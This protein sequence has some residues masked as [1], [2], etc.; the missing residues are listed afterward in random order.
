MP[1]RAGDASA[2]GG[3]PPPNGLAATE[4]DLAEAR[5][6]RRMRDAVADRRAR[7]PC[8]L[9]RRRAA[10]ATNDNIDALGPVTTQVMR[11]LH[12]VSS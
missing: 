4:R 2:R 6:S 10:L 5:P 12:G 9:T 8:A 3:A 11:T 1:D 7:V